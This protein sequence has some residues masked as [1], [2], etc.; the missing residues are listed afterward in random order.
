MDKRGAKVYDV[1]VHACSS[2]LSVKDLPLRQ[3]LCIGGAISPAPTRRKER[4]P[5][6][7]DG[8]TVGP[9]HVGEGPDQAHQGSA[10]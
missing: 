10:P 3:P 2:F 6:W 4:H 5:L 7:R 8:S 1:E 9:S